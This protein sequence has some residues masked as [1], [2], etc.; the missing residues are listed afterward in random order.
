VA[1]A[2]PV[3]RALTYVL[4]IPLGAVAYVVWRRNRSWCRPPGGAPRTDLVR[5]W[6]EPDSGL[7][8]VDEG[9]P[10]QGS[11]ARAADAGTAEG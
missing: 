7:P 10:V 3:F 11:A 8:A 9:Q 5:E 1:A 2:V 4:P 6:V